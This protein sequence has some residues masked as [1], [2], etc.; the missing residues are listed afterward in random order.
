MLVNLKIT[1]LRIAMELIV[2][3]E[4]KIK[5]MLTGEDM[6]SYSGSTKEI[7]STIMNDVRNKCGCSGMSGRIFIQM[8]P[9]KGGGCEMFVT[10]LSDDKPNEIKCMRTGEERVLTEYRKYIYTERGRYVIYSFENM[11]NMLRC[12]RDLCG[13]KYNGSSA[14]YVEREKRIFYLLLESE[15]H[16]AGENFGK[17]C[18]SR[19]YYY[20]N[21]HCDVMCEKSA[22][23][24]L[25]RFAL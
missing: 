22:V 10:K 14:A 25:A 12:C 1:E 4:S 17:L 16:A 6:A 3:S 2:I 13:M 9:S 19:F 5:L 20:I 15:T 11:E 8:Y 18:P 7:L 24:I 21:E 23:E